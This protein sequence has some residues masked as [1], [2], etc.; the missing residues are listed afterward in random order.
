MPTYG[1]INPYGMTWIEGTNLEEIREKAL[2]HAYDYPISIWQKI[3]TVK[4]IDKSLE[5][6]HFGLSFDPE[7][8]DQF[9]AISA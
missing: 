8:P 7:N 4:K 6:S 9:T 2:S 1:F 3:D 5:L